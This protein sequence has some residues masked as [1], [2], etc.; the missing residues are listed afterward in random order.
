[1]DA[2]PAQPARR[3]PVSTYTRTRQVTMYKPPKNAP[4]DPDE[5]VVDLLIR[6]IKPTVPLA[7]AACTG[8]PELFD[9]DA[10]PEQHAQAAEICTRCPVA[11][12]CSDWAAAQ[13]KNVSGVIA[14]SLMK[15]PHFRNRKESPA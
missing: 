5:H 10:T 2:R 9:I 14:G 11:Q 6:I 4:R 3:R 13:R 12:Q 7:G 8:H 15:G 1:M